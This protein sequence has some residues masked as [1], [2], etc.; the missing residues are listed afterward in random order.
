MS[1]GK[2][3]SP[4]C[5]GAI[6]K[7]PL[8]ASRC[9]H[10]LRPPS[11]T[12][13]RVFRHWTNARAFKGYWLETVRRVGIQNLRFHDLRHTF[14]TRLQTLGVD[15]EL[16]QALLGH[17]MPR[18]TADYSHGG[19]EGDGRLRDAVARLEKAMCWPVVWP[20]NGQRPWW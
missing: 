5:E 14:T 13:G 8:S 20:V 17:R 6:R 2:A 9:V 15:S 16:C 3:P 18:M 19:A 4:A 11:V 7:S 1:R 12:D 10:W